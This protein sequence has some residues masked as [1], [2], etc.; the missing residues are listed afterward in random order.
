MKG[1]DRNT[2]PPVLRVMDRFE[3]RNFTVLKLIFVS[4]VEI[5]CDLRR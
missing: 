2:R 3:I 4:T 5:D 1:G